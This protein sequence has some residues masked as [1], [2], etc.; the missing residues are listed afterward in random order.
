MTQRL[1]AVERLSA[2]RRVRYRRF[3]C[4]INRDK[5]E[6]VTGRLLNYLHIQFQMFAVSNIIVLGQSKL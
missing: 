1:S 2:S 5:K 3:E 6:V 4:I